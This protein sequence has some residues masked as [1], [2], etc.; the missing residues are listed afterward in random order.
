MEDVVG[1]F[2]PSPEAYEANLEEARKLLEGAG[3]QFDESGMLSADT[4]INMTYLTV[5]YFDPSPEAYEANLEE[6][7]KLLE[8]AGYQFDESGML[9]AD[10]PINMTYLTNDSEGNAKIGE[11]IQQD[12]AAIGINVT[13][14]TR[15]WSVFLDERK[16]GKR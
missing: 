8:G 6:A 10:T 13:V 11:S 5:G 15:E 14:E 2:D 12:F 9:S 7:R 3:Y 16:Q 4:P 1:Y